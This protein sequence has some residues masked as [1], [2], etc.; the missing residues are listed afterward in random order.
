MDFL[1]LFVG[2]F[3]AL[4][5][6]GWL[7]VPKQAGSTNSCG[8][9][10]EWDG[11]HFEIDDPRVPGAVRA[12]VKRLPLDQY[13]LFYANTTSRGEWWLMVGDEL[14]KAYWQEPPAA[15]RPDRS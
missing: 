12:R 8:G 10:P 2:V 13:H 3:I 1:L 4:K 6:L 9:V 5:A 7:I 14:V 15:S 11:Q